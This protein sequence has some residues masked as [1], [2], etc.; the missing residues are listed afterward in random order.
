MVQYVET[1]GGG[2]EV[3]REVGEEHG[4]SR[5]DRHCREEGVGRRGVR[6]RRLRAGRLA[7]SAAALQPTHLETW[8]RENAASFAPFGR[9]I[10]PE[11]SPTQVPEA[12][13]MSDVL[14]TNGWLTRTDFLRLSGD[15]MLAHPEFST[16]VELLPSSLVSQAAR[17][18]PDAAL[19]EYFMG[20]RELVILLSSWDGYAIRRLAVDR[21]TLQQWMEK[22]RTDEESARQLG[23]V[24]L[25]PMEPLLAGR[26]LTLVGHGPLLS[27]PWD[28]LELRQGPMVQLH[29]WRLWAGPSMSKSALDSKGPHRVLA[30]G[31]V[32]GL[33]LP[34]SEREVG[35][36]RESG[37]GSVEVLTGPSANTENLKRLLPEANVLHLATHSTPTEIQLSD[38]ILPLNEVYALPLR[39]GTLVVLS[40]CEGADPGEQQRGPVT[41]AAA[42]LA[43]G[44]SEVIAGTGRVNDEEAEALFVEFYRA[45]GKGLSPSAALR[46]AKL[47]R[48][49]ANPGGDWSKFVLMGG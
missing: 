5:R 29:E 30:L 33:R 26:R 35:A 32:S 27:L 3:L 7:S 12:R 41:L 49:E 15:I 16:T 36:L 47:K 19:V 4:R 46:W 25:E 11:T 21:D 44:A 45:L 14:E 38:R 18:E 1:A 48:R 37:V 8:I 17:L 6:G 9:E 23:R 39:T 22:V 31:G 13:A 28:L 40:S 2:A 10:D 43:A 24:L 34:G 20:E 42:F